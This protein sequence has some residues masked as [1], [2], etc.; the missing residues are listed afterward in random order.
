MKQVFSSLIVLAFCVVA[1]AQNVAKPENSSAAMASL[2]V[3]GGEAS[4]SKGSVVYSVGTIFYTNIETQH[5][6]VSQCIQQAK[7]EKGNDLKDIS[8]LRV[9]AYPNPTT[10]YVLIDILD[11]G[12]E[13]A[14]Y[15]LFD[16]RGSLVKSERIH[17]ATTKLPMDDLGASTYF[18]KVIV[19]N[20]FEKTLPLI[21]M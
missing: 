15:E 10:D 21:K 2:N 13:T 11:Y 5:N 3:S 1:K 8:E 4:S 12:N 6:T 14:R 20:R 18:L 7:L 16:S 9:M 19:M 17:T